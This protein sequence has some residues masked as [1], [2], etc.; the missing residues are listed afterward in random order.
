MMEHVFWRWQQ[1]EEPLTLDV[2]HALRPWVVVHF[3]AS[4]DLLDFDIWRMQPAVEARRRAGH[5]ASSRRKEDV[6]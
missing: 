5:D 4:I 6:A 2:L 1:R 3:P